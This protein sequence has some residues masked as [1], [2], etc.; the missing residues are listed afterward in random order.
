[1]VQGRWVKSVVWPAS[2]WQ[3]AG[4]LHGCP[5]LWV[6]VMFRS[7][8]FALSL[9]VLL[10]PARLCADPAA[11]L[12]APSRPCLIA[13]LQPALPAAPPPGV[14]PPDMAALV[15]ALLTARAREGEAIGTLAPIWGADTITRSRAEA[16]GAAG[17]LAALA[18][19]A[20]EL[21]A[22]ASMTCRAS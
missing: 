9:M 8:L 14:V 11:C 4:L 18:A 20:G 2:G 17:Y 1:M 5:V 10:S 6:S 15:Q 16:L 21:R 12:A 22:A 13:L 3:A 19:L 7:S